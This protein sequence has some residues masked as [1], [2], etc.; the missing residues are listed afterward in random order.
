MGSG[1]SGCPSRRPARG[2]QGPA[3]RRRRAR[4]AGEPP[5]PGA[6]GAWGCGAPTRR[7]RGSL[8]VSVAAGVQDAATGNPRRCCPVGLRGPPDPRLL[9]LGS[10]GP[11]LCARNSGS[12]GERC[13]PPRSRPPAS[14]RCTFAP[15]LALPS[16]HFSCFFPWETA[17]QL[18]GSAPGVS[19]RAPQ[20]DGIQ[21]EG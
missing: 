5:W 11:V 16:S 14:A 15:V 13:L 4:L 2:V 20:S 3:E 17:P 12:G 7:G 18:R 6:A 1:G 19:S 10:L 8:R 21:D 9:C